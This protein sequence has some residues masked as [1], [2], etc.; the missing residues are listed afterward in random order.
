[1][2]HIPK[3]L[4]HFRKKKKKEKKER[5]IKAAQKTE[6][7]ERRPKPYLCLVLP[8]SL[9][10]LLTIIGFF[11][12]LSTVSIHSRLLRPPWRACVLT[13]AL[14]V[15]EQ[16]HRRLLSP[17]LRQLFSLQQRCSGTIVA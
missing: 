6:E 15:F 3:E 2:Q 5:K 10:L 11:Q 16:A 7:E 9:L 13:F 4:K 17:R 12:L 1:L 14:L 8:T